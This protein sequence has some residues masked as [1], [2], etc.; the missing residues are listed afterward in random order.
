MANIAKIM[1]A[2]VVTGEYT[3][4]QGEQK[5]SY[6]KIGTLFVYD[7]NGMSL[8]L[9]AL[10]IG[11]PNINFYERKPKQSGGHQ[12][13]AQQSQ[14]YQQ[15]QQQAPQGQA[16]QHEGYPTQYGQQA[17]QVTPP[18]QQHQPMPL[19]DVATEQIPFSPIGMSEGGYFV[20][21]I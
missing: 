5:K 4:A 19:V 10:P 21:L 7:D 17:S 14:G 6:L 1:D 9:D 15:G 11:N 13:P 12:Q 16:V 8:K 3:N 18:A 2:T 20:H